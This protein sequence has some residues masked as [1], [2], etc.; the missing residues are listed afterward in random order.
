MITLNK[1]SIV[2]YYFNSIKV[3]LKH[4]TKNFFAS[5]GIF[6]FHK[7]TIKTHQRILIIKLHA[8]FN[9]IKVQLKQG[10]DPSLSVFTKI[11]IP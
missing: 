1:C 9:S 10:T 5:R 2:P 6:Q 4:K 7:G 8:H 3:Q 11:S